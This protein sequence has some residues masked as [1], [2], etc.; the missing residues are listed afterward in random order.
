MV[1]NPR[2]KSWKIFNEN[3]VG[4]HI[5]KTKVVLNK[6]IYVGASILDLSKLLMYDFHCNVKKKYGDKLKLLA[7]DTDSL[8]YEIETED[9][10]KDMIN[11]KDYF[12]FSEYNKDHFC[13]DPTNAKV[14]DKF[15]DETNGNPIVEFVGLRPKM[16]TQLVY[17][18]STYLLL[19][20]T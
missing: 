16:Y 6:P 4:V 14:I 9:L 2:L 3:L 13:F 19:K 15:K 1:A 12:D 7:T 20:Y 17:Y 8:K 10:Y 5:Y 11:I 18:T